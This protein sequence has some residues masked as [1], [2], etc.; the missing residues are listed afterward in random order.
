MWRVGGG[1]NINIWS[2]P[3]VG[4]ERGR[5]ILSNRVEG[6]NTVSDLIDDTTKEWKFEAIERHFGERDQKCILS[7]P[8]SSRETEDVLTWAY[9][10]DGLYSVKTTYMIGKGG[11]LEDFHQ[12]WVVLWGLDVSPKV[13][14]FLWR[15]C[16]SSLPTRATLMARHLLEEGGCS[17]CPSELETSHH[18]IFACA[19]IRRL[20]VDHGC[21]AMVGDGR[22][23]GGCEMLE[24]WKSLDKK[25]VQ[26]GCFLAWNIWAERNR[27]VFENICQPLPIISQRVCRQVDDHNE[28]TTRIYG[29][30]ACV[31]PVSSSHWC[32]PPEGVIKLNTDA[33][34]EANG[35]VS[36]AT[37]ARNTCGQV[38]FA[39]VRRQ[40]AYWPPDIAE[41]KAILFAVRMAKARGLPN[42]MVESDALVVIS[43]LSKAALFYFDLDAIMGDVFSLSVC[44]NAISFN[45]VKR[46]GNA[47][48]HHLARVV[49]FGLEQCWENHCPR[50]VTPYIL[51]DTLSLD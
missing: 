19:R 16:T 13:R 6:L 2:D 50:E 30:P 28:Y 26:K 29:Q 11:N 49:P 36:V 18:A 23:E 31:R 24:R 43:R 21:E 20:W 42:V 51:M 39:A 37:V 45:H 41:C 22:V 48:A 9:S 17:W 14:H 3:W 33:H 27:F 47:V 8:L 12:A 7:I 5:F 15:Y 25:I 4:D 10:K 44:F 1:R 32:A 35:W 46:D 34:I 38:L 40:R